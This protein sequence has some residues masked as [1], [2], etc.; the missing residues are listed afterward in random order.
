LSNCNITISSTGV[1]NHI[2]AGPVFSDGNSFI[3]N[4]GIYNATTDATN[5]QMSAPVLNFNMFVVY[6]Q[7]STSSLTSRFVCG[8]NSN[9]YLL[10]STL[11]V[12]DGTFTISAG[13]FYGNGIIPTPHFI[14][15]SPDGYLQISAPFKLTVIGN[16]TFTERST[17]ILTINGVDIGQVDTFNVTGRFFDEFSHP[18]EVGK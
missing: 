14:F 17:V 15:D 3:T 1:F 2:A 8:A 13:F 7:N 4:Y 10:D 16:A 5:M 12:P 11:I 18:L 9:F 6:G